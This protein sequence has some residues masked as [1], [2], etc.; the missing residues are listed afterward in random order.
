MSEEKEEEPE[1]QFPMQLGSYKLIEMIGSGG[2][3]EVF[4]AED[5]I[6]QRT[7]ALKRIVPKHF[8]SKR[9]RERFLS[10]PQIAAKLSHPSIIPIY[11][12][13]DEPDNLFYTM[14]YIEGETL[15]ELLV[16][17]RYAKEHALP[18]H[19]VG[20]S[21]YALMLMFLNICQ[22]IHHAHS[23]GYLHRDIKPANIMVRNFTQVVIL[24]WGV[25]TPIGKMEEHQ[26]YMKK[27]QKFPENRLTSPLHPTGT[28]DY[29]APERCFENPASIQSDIYSLGATLYYMLTLRKPFERPDTYGD[30]REQLIEKGPEPVPD[31]QIIAPDREITPLLSRI[32]LKCLDAPKRR[33]TSVKELIDDINSYV[34]GKPEWTLSGEFQTDHSN[35]W[36]F[37]ENV[38]LAKHMAISRY[39]GMMEWV[40][41]MLSREVYS[42]NIQLKAQVKLKEGCRGIGFLLCVPEKSERES[43]ETGYLFWIGSKEHPGCQFLR[44]NVEVISMEHIYCEPEQEYALTIER[45]DNT[46]RLYLNGELVMTYESHVPVIGG[47]FGLLFRDADF[48][49][50]PIALYMGSQNVQ[51]NCLSIP[52]AFL[53]IKDYPKAL[54]EYQHIARSF[55]GR[56]E[57]REATFRAGITLIEMGKYPD[58][59]REFEKLHKTPGAPLEYLGKSLVYQAEKNTDEEAKCLELAIRMFPKHPLTH[60]IKEHLI[61]RLHETAQKDRIGAYTFALLAI[62]Q[63]PSIYEREETQNF[64]K[65]L[66]VS[67]ET[68]PFI[69]TPAN[70]PTEKLEQ[71]NLSIH[72]AFWLARPT[73]LYELTQEI[74]TSYDK[75]QLLLENALLAL[76]ALGYP[77]LVEFILNVKFKGDPKL[78]DLKNTFAILI[79]DSPITKKLDLLLT[80]V[81][82]KYFIPLLKQHLTIKQA[83]ALL[84]Y[85][86][87]AP[88]PKSM[89]IE[90]LLFAGKTNDAG[91]L[92]KGENT[93]DTASDFYMLQGCYLAKTKGEKAALAHFDG[94]IESNFPKTPTLLGRFLNGAIKSSWLSCAFLWEKLELYR[95]LTLYYTCLGK[96][97]KAA[98]YQK[99][100]EQE[101][102]KSQIPLNFI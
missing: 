31:P 14:P 76:L 6:C 17:T 63:I 68:L 96:S 46:F 62:R 47:H 83:S 39:A 70:M 4:L 93:S 22:A 1:Y 26:A 87:E 15:S 97:Q 44:S 74:P 60:V 67:W 42:G 89:H 54:S 66:R 38:L 29:M 55:K 98:Q 48:E 52:D 84:P 61:F 81:P 21:V 59:L 100:V 35:D 79:D 23:R 3:G 28:T 85:F 13:H 69:E 58:A 32:A 102:S 30:W 37:Q 34:Q 65:N 49:I 8:D 80:K 41:L 99:M 101:F 73:S 40:M 20:S 36:E 11:S 88:L 72:L 90:A 33:Y 75:R 50:S 25:A 43:L 64:I 9:T 82:T 57:G 95:Q 91:K 27:H 18:P 5:P 12:L 24:D 7:V 45:Q 16:K 86:K 53:M 71:V 19:M 78:T 77:K 2:M 94:L 10:E 92:L 51:V 56:A